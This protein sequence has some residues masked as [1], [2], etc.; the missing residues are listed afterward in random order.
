MSNVVAFA[1]LGKFTHTFDRS[2]PEL[3]R[4]L[5]K[6]HDFDAVL[7]PSRFVYVAVVLNRRN[8]SEI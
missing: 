4:R 2:L 3:S 5:E 7:Y 1:K 8:L 6:W